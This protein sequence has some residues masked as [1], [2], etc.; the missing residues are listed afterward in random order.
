MLLHGISVL[1]CEVPLDRMSQ[2]QTPIFLQIVP[3]QRAYAQET[4][5]FANSAAAL[6]DIYWKFGFLTTKFK[7]SSLHAQFNQELTNILA[8]LMEMNP[9]TFFEK[10]NTLFWT[11]SIKY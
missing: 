8:Y 9:T 11:M 10:S 5:M 1:A 4:S 6:T 7:A 2:T 3:R